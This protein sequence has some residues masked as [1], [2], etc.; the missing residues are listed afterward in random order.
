MKTFNIAGIEIPNRYVLAPL[1]GY[2][3][4]SMRKLC[5]DY[6]AGLVYTEME[7]CESLYYN[8]KATKQDLKATHLD[9]T[10]GKSKLALQIFGG[11]KDIILKS[12]PMFEQLGRYD[13][14]D[15]NC[16]CP[17][18]KVIR[19]NAG[20]SWLNRPDE[21]VDLMNDI[22]HLS[23]KPVIIKI[24]IGFSNI[25][26]IVSLCKRLQE[27]G[28]KAI[29]VHGRTRSEMF[30]GPVHYDVIKDIKKN[31]DIPVIANGMIDSNNFM[32]ILD[33]TNADAVMIGQKAI[34][35]PKVFENM[36]RIEKG[37]S[38]Y[39][40]TLERQIDDLRKQIELIYQIK[41]ERQASGIMRSV[42]VHYMKGFDNV[43]KYR[44]ELV[45]CESKEDYMNVL[46]RMRSEQTE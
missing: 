12:I 44:L 14:L 33:K 23:S 41:D 43:K 36:T 7:S 42:S 32:D 15:F 35:Y 45:H 1:A 3:D 22:V 21:L 24:R 2:T 25:I 9:C 34:G 31:L 11:K 8:S 46:N 10:D 40:D 39:P 29:A 13:F 37:L 27:V 26:D 5:S 28:V 38:P 20:S 6:G 30:S 19:Q 16:G 4:H 18:P 17:V